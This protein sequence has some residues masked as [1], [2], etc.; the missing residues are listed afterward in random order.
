MLKL[1]CTIFAFIQPNNLIINR[2][3][4][5]L[6]T[7]NYPL[8]QYKSKDNNDNNNENNGLIRN[9]NNNIYY[10]GNLHD[11][12]IFAITSNIINLQ[13]E[14]N[15][16]NINLH[17]QSNGGSL[18]PS[19][20]LIDLIKIS[21]IPINTYIMGYAASAASLISV[22]GSERYISRHGVILIHQLKMGIEYSKFNEIEDQY[23]NAKT[24][25]D[26]IKN[27]YLENTNLNAKH[28]NYLLEHDFWLNSTLCKKYGLVDY[29]L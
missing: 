11:E 2:R 6:T 4:L 20:G 8:Y 19:L 16:K 12:S 3:N 9:V 27:I 21:N 10:S 24:L 25:M 18:L 17:I 1:L 15:I 14:D 29:I 7:M 23:Y 5:I 28:L 13:N 26:L 22:V